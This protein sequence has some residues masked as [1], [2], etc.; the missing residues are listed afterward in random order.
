MSVMRNVS[1]VLPHRIESGVFRSILG[2]GT[3]NCKSRMYAAEAE[4][5]VNIKQGLRKTRFT[6]RLHCSNSAFI[7]VG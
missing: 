5:S 2:E 4:A 7:S 3:R 6:S 1:L